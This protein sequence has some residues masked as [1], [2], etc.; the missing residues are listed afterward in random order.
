ME[1]PDYFINYKNEVEIVRKA[2]IPITLI[3]GADDPF[4]NMSYIQGMSLP[5]N[6]RMQ[7]INDAGHLPFLSNPDCITK[8]ISKLI[9]DDY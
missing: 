1:K 7:I 8:E 6:C 4:L 2:Q 3:Y 5:Q 9:N